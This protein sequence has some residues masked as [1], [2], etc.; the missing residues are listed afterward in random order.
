MFDARFVRMW[1]FYLAGAEQGFRHGQLVNFQFQ[2]TRRRDALPMTREY[3]EAEAA[4][5]V[6][7]DAAPDAQL[8]SSV[9]R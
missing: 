5:L 7:A 4:R 2:T 6:A 8:R 1:Q 9:A 3:I